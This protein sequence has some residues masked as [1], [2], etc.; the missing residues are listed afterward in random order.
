[1]GGGCVWAV[2]HISGRR[3]GWLGMRRPHLP[4]LPQRALVGE[5]ALFS[6][7]WGFAFPPH[8]AYLDE[9]L[10][11]WLLSV[12]FL[13]QTAQQ[14]CK[15]S[16]QS[17]GACS[18]AG[19]GGRMPGFPW[20]SALQLTKLSGHRTSVRSL[21][22]LGCPMPGQGCGPMADFPLLGH[23]TFCLGCWVSWHHLV[24]SFTSV[25]ATRSCVVPQ[26][27]LCHLFLT[28]SLP[29]A[30]PQ[31]PRLIASDVWLFA[32]SE[33]SSKCPTYWFLAAT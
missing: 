3:T 13:Q 17:E 8:A 14:L 21:G 2:Q 10:H 6:P 1:M 16:M 19:F 20:I 24:C 11:R 30:V 29:P 27:C 4:Q 15:E 12:M 28:T 33:L 23:F 31:H 25:R 18:S 26:K 22:H 7:A 32:G 5:G 9:L